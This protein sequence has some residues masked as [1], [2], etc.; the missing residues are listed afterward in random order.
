MLSHP[1]ALTRASRRIAFAVVLLVSL[2]LAQAL[3]LMH[4]I[5]H[6]RHAPGTVSTATVAK[7][8]DSGWVAKLF[9][10]HQ[11][12]GD[13]DVYDQLSHGDAMHGATPAFAAVEFTQTPVALHSG[14]H[15]A[16][17]SSGFLARGPP[18]LS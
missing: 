18:S 2:V 6:M 8:A 4:G 3:G 14:W 9:A 13:C 7:A 15:I 17:Q 16:A 11:H 10:G 1:I 12:G 5:A